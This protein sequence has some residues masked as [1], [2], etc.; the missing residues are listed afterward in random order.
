[1]GDFRVEVNAVGGHGC[2]R[3]SR[4]G[5]T[6]YGCGHV[7][8]PDCITARYIAEM[9]R[10]GVAVNHATITHWPGQPS[11]VRDSF[12]VHVGAMTPNGPTRTRSGSF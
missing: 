2:C 3:D 6:V 7:S 8:C 5:E 1:M 9:M 10:A 4:D 12:D 11:E